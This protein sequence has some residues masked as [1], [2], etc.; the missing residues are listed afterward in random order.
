MSEYA[1]R[2]KQLAYYM[3]SK[4][5][6]LLPAAPSV[7]RN[8]ENEYPYRQNSD[9]YYMTGFEEPDAV[10]V[11][12]PGHPEGEFILFNR[13]RD[14]GEEIWTGYRAGQE[15]AVKDWGADQAFPIQQ[16]VDKLPALLEGFEVVHYSL[17]FNKQFDELV[18]KVMHKVQGKIRSGVRPPIVF[19]D[20]T[21]SIHEMRLIK[22]P[23]EIELMKKAADISAEG[24]IRAM[25]RC[26]PGIYEY[27]LEAELLYEFYRAGSRFPAYA[28]IVGSGANSC[29][30]HYTK[31][32]QVICENDLVL[33]DAGCEYKYYASD[34][35]RTFPA[36][37]RFSGEQKA[38]Y[39]IV[40]EAQLA[41]IAAIA[42]GML[43]S[44]P[45][46]AITRVITQGLIDLGILKGGVTELVDAEAFLPFY[47][48]RS[49]HW[50]GLDV[51]DVGYYKVGGKW[52]AFE[53]GMVLTVEPGIYIS[54][55][56]PDVDARWHHIGVRIEDDIVVTQSGHEVISQK[57]PKSVDDIE[58]LMR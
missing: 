28:P 43:W 7:F 3:G 57:A 45:Q 11:I 51:H 53:P 40:L 22:S 44:E 35:T 17:G 21:S 25:K 47:M 42:P 55:D 9:F 24:H 56:I 50:L 14:R 12:A 32:D 29:V 19:K 38:I 18:M 52:R 5:I 20:I 36:Q 30:L 13:V 2:R 1:A 54:A 4:G 58:A 8:S 27:E 26:K 49:G 34:V 23:A 41:G 15:G 46:D 33:I 16:L 6:A 39:D 48:H 31:N 37:G 10:A